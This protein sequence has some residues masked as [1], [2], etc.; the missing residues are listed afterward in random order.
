MACVVGFVWSGVGHDEKRKK[1]AEVWKMIIKTPFS[2]DL[3]AFISHSINLTSEPA[4]AR[5]LLR[6][7]TPFLCA[8]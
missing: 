2:V 5:A 4:L 7:P 3:A 1:V 6:P 8:K